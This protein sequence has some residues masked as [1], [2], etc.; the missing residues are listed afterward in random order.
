[1][2][3][4]SISIDGYNAEKHDAFRCVPGAFDATMRGIECL[5]AEGVEFQINTTVTRDNLHVFKKSYRL[6]AAHRRG[7][8]HHLLLVPMGRPPSLRIR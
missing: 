3:R 6:C 8:V 5:K 7:G 2:Q 4:C 1:M